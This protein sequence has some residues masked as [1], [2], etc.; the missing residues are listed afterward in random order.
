MQTK[1]VQ[2]LELLSAS[3]IWKYF[4]IIWAVTAF[5]RGD[6][7]IRFS[8]PLF[9]ASGQ[10]DGVTVAVWTKD[11][12]LRKSARQLLSHNSRKKTNVNRRKGRRKMWWKKNDKNWKRK[13]QEKKE[14][15]KRI[16][17]KKV[18]KLALICFVQ[19]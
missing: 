7:P 5:G 19:C 15:E 2:A 12:S 3:R 16:G 4:G 6:W 1:K 13:R 10:M 11:L 8:S 14:T 9:D 17:P 18:V